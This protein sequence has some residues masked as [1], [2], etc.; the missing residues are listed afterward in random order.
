M[1]SEIR[2]FSNGA[3]RDSETGKL[4]YEGFLSPYALEAFAK[5]MDRHRLQTDGTLRPS[6]NWQKGI[7][8]ESYMKSM[9]RHMFSMWKV[10]R[11]GRVF[12]ERDE[13]E[14][15][16][17][18]SACGVMFNAMGYLHVALKNRDE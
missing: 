7:P 1:T 13:H 2:T 10:Y 15:D 6:D 3:T 12:D 8:I 14:V 5:Y 11:G 4:D 16:M 9:W 17:I 18:E